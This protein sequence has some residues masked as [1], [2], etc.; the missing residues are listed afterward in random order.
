LRLQFH[1]PNE[2]ESRPDME[3]DDQ[4]EIQYYQLMFGKILRDLESQKKEIGVPREDL[5]GINL[6]DG[7]FSSG[8]SQV[9]SPMSKFMK[10]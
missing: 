10:T 4:H 5:R 6:I 9:G 3:I 1:G 7:L 2:Q 8:V